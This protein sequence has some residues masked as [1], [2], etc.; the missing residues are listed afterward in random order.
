MSNQ[1]ILKDQ[2]YVGVDGGGSKCRAIIYSPESGVLAEALSG[3]ANFLRGGEQ[4]ITHVIEATDAALAQLSLTPDSKQELI[5]GIGLAG[6]NLESCMSE[7]KTWQHPF[8][9]AYF[10]SDLEVACCGAHTG[11]D[12]IVIIAGTGSSAVATIDGKAKTLGGHGFPVG[13]WGSGAWLGLKAV[14][15]TLQ[16]MDNLL[17]KSPMT[18]AIVRI[19]GVQEAVDL[20]QIVSQ[21]QP[22]DYAKLSPTVIEFALQKDVYAL[23]IVETGA[24]YLSKVALELDQQNNLPLA[25]IGG[26]APV[27]AEF[28]DPK[29]QAMIK[30]ADNPPEVG[31]AL[32]AMQQQTLNTSG[33]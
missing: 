5:A 28:F 33:L 7:I 18:D 11:K 17:E 15:I 12:G 21:F 3:P 16:V 14:E 32:F 6:L 24:D 22:S 4:A 10:G 30:S 9:Q 13:D 1:E 31:A 26:L 29:V 27:I 23:D 2:L 20:A 19:Y 25:L 8:K